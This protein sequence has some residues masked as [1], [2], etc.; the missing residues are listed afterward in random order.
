MFI[1]AECDSFLINNISHTIYKENI[2]SYYMEF[3]S[4]ENVDMVMRQTNYTKEKAE[5]KL[6]EHNNVTI[7]VIKEYLNITEKKE[8]EEKKLPKNLLNI[9]NMREILKNTKPLKSTME[10]LS[11]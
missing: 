8:T 1:N 6:S 4:I 3:V 2:I 10:H 7:N 11:Q 5:Q 9:K